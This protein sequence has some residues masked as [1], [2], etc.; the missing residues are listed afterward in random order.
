M[1]NNT[2]KRIF[3]IVFS[4]WLKTVNKRLLLFGGWIC[5]TLKAWHILNGKATK[6]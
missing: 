6:Y 4:R 5:S 3:A 2:N 1:L